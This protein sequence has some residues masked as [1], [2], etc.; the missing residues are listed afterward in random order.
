VRFGLVKEYEDGFHG[1][2]DINF[3]ALDTFEPLNRWY[4]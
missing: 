2:F 3:D 1:I 4:A